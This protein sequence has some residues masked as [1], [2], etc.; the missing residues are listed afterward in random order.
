MP[1]TVIWM[2]KSTST[3]VR[4]KRYLALGG[5]NRTAS[6]NLFSSGFPITNSSVRISEICLKWQPRTSTP[7]SMSFRIERKRDGQ[8]EDIFEREV[9]PN[10][11]NPPSLEIR[12]LNIPCK[13]FDELFGYVIN[14]DIALPASPFHLGMIVTLR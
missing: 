7:Y 5:Q 1:E 3:A 10:S 14:G 11:P 12:G 9:Q 4:A 13:R 8:V 2:S 6:G